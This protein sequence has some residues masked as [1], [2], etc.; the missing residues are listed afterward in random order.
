MAVSPTQRSAASIPSPGSPAGSSPPKPPPAPN[1][2]AAISDAFQPAK[3]AAVPAPASPPPPARREADALRESA[4]LL[5]GASQPDAYDVRDG[6]TVQLDPDDVNDSADRDPDS[7]RFQA[8]TEQVGRNAPLEGARLA[9]LSAS[10]R[11]HYQQVKQALAA[12][13]VAQLALQRQLFSG[14]VPGGKD[15][16]GQGTTLDHLA[17]LANPNTALAAGIDRGALLA[18][19]V[20]ELAVPSAIAQ[21]TKNTCGPTTASI[22]V[23]MTR[24]AE[25]ARLVTGLASPEGKVTLADGST[26][27]R[28]KDTIADDG[29]GR[30]A[31]QRLLEPALMDRANG[32]AGYDNGK[33]KHTVFGVGTVPGAL[34]DMIDSCLSAV[35]GKSF[36]HHD[37]LLWGKGGK[38]DQMARE[39]AKGT[40]V[41]AMISY[42]GKLDLHWVMVTGVS[43]DTV[44]Y[45]NPWGREETMPRGK[46][47]DVL[48]G[49]TWDPKA[50]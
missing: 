40:P 22:Y 26:L 33:D 21:Q 35:L 46:F 5:C 10:D 30:S 28:V 11:A 4:V 19:T 15:A 37:L 25:Y 44:R 8:A 43:K 6:A 12:D 45:I 2:A 47:E 27:G 50:A 38:V 36:E 48:R 34:P 3:A 23:A 16:K 1:K 18:D 49:M 17:Q 13:P 32:I 14:Q 7:G 29:S 9:N 20:Q 42:G 39:T 41:P 31:S 24:P